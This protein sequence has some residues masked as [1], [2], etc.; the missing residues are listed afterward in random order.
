MPKRSAG[1]LMYRLVGDDVEVLLVYPDGPYW[2]KKDDGAWSVRMASTRKATTRSR[3][4]IREFIE[5]LG[6]DPPD[7]SVAAFLGVARQPNGKVVRR[8]GP[9]GQHRRYGDPQQHVH[10]GMI[11]Q[12]GRVPRGRPGG[13]VRRG[14][15]RR[16]L[17]RGQVAFLDRLAEMLR[18]PTRADG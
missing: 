1:L 16:K 4:A 8:L 5:K 14:A 6:A 2:A 15:A 7:A 17:L 3:P 9:R 12:D 13:V 10:D 18:A 11:G